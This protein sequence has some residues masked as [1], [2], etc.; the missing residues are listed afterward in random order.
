MQDG[1]FRITRWPGAPISTARYIESINT[2]LLGCTTGTPVAAYRGNSDFDTEKYT[3]TY[4]SPVLSF[5]DP[6][7]SKFVRQIDYLVASG[8]NESESSGSWEYVGLRPY[9]KR[10]YITLAGGSAN[11][12]NSD[13]FLYNVAKYGLGNDVVRSYKINAD[14]SGENVIVKFSAVVDNSICSLQQINIQALLGRIT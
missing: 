12:Y 5:G 1:S 14:G 13:D 8:L 3:F 11:F 2:M 9:V 4:S 6:V 10:K 7:R